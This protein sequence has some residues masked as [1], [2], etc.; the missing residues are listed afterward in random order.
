MTNEIENADDM[1]IVPTLKMV[2]DNTATRMVDYLT[3]LPDTKGKKPLPTVGNFRAMFDRVGIVARYNVIAKDV[4]IS[5]PGVTPLPDNALNVALTHIGSYAE[6]FGVGSGKASEITMAIADENKFNPVASWIM[7]RPWDGQSRIEAFLDTIETTPGNKD[8]KDLLLLK[9]AIS[10]IAA[11]SEP[12]GIS[13][14]GVLVF[15]GAQG[16]GKTHWFKKLV[17]YEMGLTQ[18][19]MML[20][21]NDKDSIKQVC[22]KW[23]VELGELDATFKKSEIS[24]LKAFITRQTD[25]LRVPYARK[26]STFPR[27]TVFFASVNQADF[28]HDDTGSR[29]FWVIPCTKINFAHGLDM[30]QVWREIYERLYLKGVPYI[31]TSDQQAMLNESNRDFEAI[32]PLAEILAE[33]YNWDA[34]V[35]SWRWVSVTVVAEEIL[36]RTPTK[37]ELSRVKG[38]LETLNGGKRKKVNG[39]RLQ[40]VP[41][42]RLGR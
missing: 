24:Q 11:L 2:V 39:N 8:L 4:E 21:L 28:L 13:A 20:N 25:I 26:E 22:S 23:L 16:L 1:P 19:G 31:L 34:P 40:L 5:I 29:R 30:Q 3:P 9:W 42:K 15:Q 18:D 41:N 36:Q 17:P 32:D 27:R 6:K 37:P 7:S 33:F 12:D 38:A 10:A 14:H 35:D